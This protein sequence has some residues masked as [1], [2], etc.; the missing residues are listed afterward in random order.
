[1][2]PRRAETMRALGISTPPPLEC[3]GKSGQQ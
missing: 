2:N 1:M 3:G